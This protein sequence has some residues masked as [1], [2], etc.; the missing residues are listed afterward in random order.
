MET[1]L[2]KAWLVAYIDSKLMG[3]VEKDLAK[4][5]EY[6][7]VEVYIPTVK[8]LKKT[9]KKEQTFEE[10]PLLFNYGFFNIP[11]ERA[12]SKTFL[13]NMKANIPC[14]FNWLTDPVKGLKRKPRDKPGGPEYITDLYIPVATVTSEDIK[15][16]IEVARESTIFSAV[17]IQRVKV[18]GTVTLRGYPWEGLEAVVKGINEKKKTLTVMI[19]LFQSQKEVSISFDSVYFTVYNEYNCNPDILS[20]HSLDDFQA[21]KVLDKVTNKNR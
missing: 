14:I 2:G 19:L 16:L 15:S 5:P 10:I 7:G 9:F 12:V 13:D 1:A 4:L 6:A 11:R 18:G 8:V 3:T 20:K 17:E 21:K